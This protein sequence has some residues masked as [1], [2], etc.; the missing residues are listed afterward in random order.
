MSDQEK[1]RESTTGLRGEGVGH[2]R[3]DVFS[4]RRILAATGATAGAL[5]AGCLGGG[6]SDGP[7]ESG[8]NGD[9]PDS[10]ET[11]STDEMTAAD[12]TESADDGTSA[13]TADGMDGTATDEVES[14]DAMAAAWQTTE[15]E[16]VRGG[17]TFAIEDLDPPVIV[18]TFAV[19]C[20][21]CQRQQEAL[22]DVSDEA[23]LV[24]LNVDANEDGDQ[25]AAHATDNGFDWRF[26]VSPGAVTGALIDEFGTD[27]TTP[28]SSP[29]VFLCGDGTTSF[30]SGD[31][32]GADGL[33]SVL[34]QC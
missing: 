9:G 2:R 1:T 23:T 18:Q 10:D 28:P 25:V 24:S 34:D 13:T 8:E 21:K 19:W 17:E 14:N 15:L 20:P 7:E 3:S 33:R 26:A 29:I 12:A 5:V 16:T 30:R 6:D 11:D 31:V 27:V 32:L 22:Q 4:R